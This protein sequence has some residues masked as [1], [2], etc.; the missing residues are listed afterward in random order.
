MK[1]LYCKSSKLS[2]GKFWELIKYFSA[3]LTATQM[4]QLSGLNINTVDRYLRFMRERILDDCKTKSTLSGILEVDESYFGARRV[5]G[6]RGGG[7]AGK[8]PVFGIFE[9]QGF[10]YTEIVPDCIKRTLQAIIRGKIEPKSIINSDGW[11]GYNGLID[12]G[13]GHYRVY[14]SKDEFVNG[15]NHINGMEGF[16]GVTKVRLSKFRN[17][18]PS[19]F[20]LHLKKTQFRYNYRHQNIGRM[21]LKICRNNPLN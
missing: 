7:T 9:R 17:M 15:P 8:T 21:I 10:V 19:T 1:N 3:D 18:H 4:A 5:K 12:M 6:K 20:L 2:E 14:H 11:R 13:Y 16:W